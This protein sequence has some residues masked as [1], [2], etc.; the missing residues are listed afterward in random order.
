M[1][2]KQQIHF[3]LFPLSGYRCRPASA[4]RGHSSVRN[5]YDVFER[6]GHGGPKALEGYDGDSDEG[7]SHGPAVDQGE[8]NYVLRASYSGLIDLAVL[9]GFGVV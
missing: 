9:P 7:C 6:H 5:G 3:F 1:I 2:W 8:S 4:L